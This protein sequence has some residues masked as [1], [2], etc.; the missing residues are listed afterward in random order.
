MFC[1]LPVSEAI[2]RL[3][4]PCLLSQG[5]ADLG[6]VA[7]GEEYQNV[8]QDECV[9]GIFEDLLYKRTDDPGPHASL[10]TGS[11]IQPSGWLMPLVHWLIL[12][13]GA[14]ELRN[15]STTGNDC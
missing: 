5:V 13:K 14:D 8:A 3:R 10:T 2:T 12:N 4:G 15:T 6:L 9:Q 11:G 1:Q 7:G